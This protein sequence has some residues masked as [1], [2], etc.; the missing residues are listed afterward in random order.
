MN[1]KKQRETMK[2]EPQGRGLTTHKGVKGESARSGDELVGRTEGKVLLK[3]GGRREMREKAS[4]PRREEG[5][6]ART[7]TQTQDTTDA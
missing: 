1:V 3:L 4:R 5:S 6:E 2:G 7:H